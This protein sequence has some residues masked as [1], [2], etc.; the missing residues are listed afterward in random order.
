VFAN[1]E[2]DR[3]PTGSGVSA[4]AALHHAKDGLLP[5]RKITIESIIGSTMTVEIVETTE[6]GNY[7]AVIP[8]V[9]GTS[10]FT[11]RHE[12]YI[13]PSD[14]LSGGFFLQ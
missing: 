13:D 10:H 11:G 3:S 1:G 7:A 8:E 6:F 9:S 5:G 2:V 14:P 4:R 12:F